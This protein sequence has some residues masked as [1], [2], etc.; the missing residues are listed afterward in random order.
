MRNTLFSELHKEMPPNYPMIQHYY[1]IWHFIKVTIQYNIWFLFS[2]FVQSILK[3]LW[4]AA[5][6]KSCS[7]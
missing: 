5:K 4:K 6:L 3:D 2:L 7:G 1:D